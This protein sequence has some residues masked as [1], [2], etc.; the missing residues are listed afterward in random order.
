MI[1][2]DAGEILD[3]FGPRVNFLSSLEL[4]EAEFTLIAGTVDPGVIVPLHSHPDRELFCLTEG[5]I[6][7]FVADQWHTIGAGEVLDIRDG[8]RHAWRN[9]S[10]S[11][12]RLLIVTTV[13]MATFLREIGRPLA[14]ANT[15]PSPGD[16]EKLISTSVHYGYW[17]G[18]PEDNAASGLSL[19]SH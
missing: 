8:V 11:P 10:E 12:V 7:A 18:S 2:V 14:A 4:G 6:E 13:R 3:V 15:P 16:I 9:M 19:P 17:N 1:P 5:S